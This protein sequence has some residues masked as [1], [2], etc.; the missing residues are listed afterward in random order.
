MDGVAGADDPWDFGTDMQYPALKVDF[1]GNGEATAY[2]FGGQGRS[3]PI[4]LS[5]ID[6]TTLEQ[7]DAMRYDLDGDGTPSGNA[8]K[9]SAYEAAFGLAVWCCNKLYRRL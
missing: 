9:V 4:P 6:I 5:L 8:T 7:L 1:D 3:V 2:E